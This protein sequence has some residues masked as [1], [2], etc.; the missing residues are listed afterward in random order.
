[1]N[2]LIKQSSTRPFLR[3]AQVALAVLA[4]GLAAVPQPAVARR[5]EAPATISI[6]TAGTDLNDPRTVARIREQI[7]IAAHDLCQ[8]DSF[9]RVYQEIARR[10]H[11]RVS[12]D[13]ERQ[14]RA[15]LAVRYAAR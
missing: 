14:L 12:A 10:C 8:S 9:A 11:E 15:R 6:P 2:H 5:S 7:R 13:A 4:A 3:K 1:M